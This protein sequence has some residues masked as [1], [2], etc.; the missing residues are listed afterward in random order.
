[1]HEPIADLREAIHVLRPTALIGVSGVASA[2]HPAVL[3]A[4]ASVTRRPLI[5]A[6][7]NPPSHAECTAE[8]A[9]RSTSGQAVFASGSPFEAV[10]LAGG[11]WS[12]GQANNVY[13]FP[14]LGL[15]AIVSEA[16][17]ITDEMFLAAADALAREV[18]AGD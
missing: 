8:S 9:Y 17:H 3:E 14:G 6:L 10:R 15:G 1:R 13:V 2:F 16:R 4:M 7:S 11:A 18:T 12:P 5:M